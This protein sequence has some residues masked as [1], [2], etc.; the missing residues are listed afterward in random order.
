MR[1]VSGTV[2]YKI[3]PFMA[4]KQN[5]KIETIDVSRPINYN[6]ELYYHEDKFQSLPKMG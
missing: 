4:K 2:A 3:T 5:T 6:R 1:L